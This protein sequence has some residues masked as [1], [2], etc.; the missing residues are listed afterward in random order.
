MRRVVGRGCLSLVKKTKPSYNYR[1]YATTNLVEST[2]QN[3]E[4]A[5]QNSGAQ[6][7]ASKDEV[8]YD[9]VANV[10]AVYQGR[11]DL[12]WTQPTP[13]WRKDKEAP[14]E[15]LDAYELEFGAHE[16]QEIDGI[17][18]PAPDPGLYDRLRKEW[19]ELP[20]YLQRIN[21]GAR[22]PCKIHL[23][24]H[25]YESH[26]AN[27]P[28]EHK[29]VSYVEHRRSKKNTEYFEIDVEDDHPPM[30]NNFNNAYEEGAAPVISDA[31]T[32][33]AAQT[34]TL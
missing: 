12:G 34:T 24:K 18:R 31:T 8:D 5:T 6:L 13:E 30:D 22:Y 4:I 26:F 10:G 20:E 33:H 28:S 21:M 32:S 14:K 9:G 25:P 3:S 17:T 29:A 7:R 16:W 27:T 23:E 2:G 1:Y 15:L 19:E 11:R